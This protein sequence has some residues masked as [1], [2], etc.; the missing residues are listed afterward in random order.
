MTIRCTIHA[1]GIPVTIFRHESIQTSENVPRKLYGLFLLH[2]R[3]EELERYAPFAERIVSARPDILVFA[4]EQRNHGSRLVDPL[5][6]ETW[7]SGNPLHALDMWSVQFGTAMDISFLITTL[8]FYLSND[9]L[10]AENSS[11]NQKSLSWWDG[12]PIQIQKWGV[13][14][15]SLGGH[16]TLLALANGTFLSVFTRCVFLEESHFGTS[17]V[18]PRLF[19]G[20]CVIGCGDYFALMRHRASTCNIPFPPD[21]KSDCYIPK[22]LLDALEVYDPVHRTQHFQGKALLLLQGAQDRLVPHSA[23]TQF[24]NALKAA[25][26]LEKDSEQTKL[27][28]VVVEEGAKHEFTESMK[29]QTLAFLDLHLS[30][31]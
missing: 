25:A 27:F 13:V 23:N 10:H 6:N 29:Q 11:L 16:A 1:G 2:G 3:L 8:P 18:E 30:K 22:S 17:C 21:P 26:Y 9:N 7:K 19:L 20:M 14:G 15:I 31:I 28:Q 24:I 12:G 4:F 5:A